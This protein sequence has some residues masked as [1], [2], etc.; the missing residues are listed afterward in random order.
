MCPVLYR[1]PTHPEGGT[2]ARI[3]G[4][5]LHSIGHRVKVVGWL[6]SAKADRNASTFSEPS[7]S[8]P[9]RVL[10]ANIGSV[11]FCSTP[12]HYRGGSCLIRFTGQLIEATATRL[13]RGSSTGYFPVSASPPGRHSDWLSA[14]TPTVVER[15][16]PT[17]LPAPGHTAP[18][19]C[20]T[21]AEK[22][23]LWPAAMGRA[24]AAGKAAQPRMPSYRTNGDPGDRRFSVH[25]TAP[26]CSAKST[27]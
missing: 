5:K 20:T 11:H 6:R 3:S 10:R 8:N 17:A 24:G 23:A 16:P 4:S 1:N 19:S 21:L 25:R 27:E 15:A 13:F 14:P 22:P 9:V 18:R 2:A 26:R 7:E 12:V